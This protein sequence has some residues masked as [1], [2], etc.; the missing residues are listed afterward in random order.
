MEIRPKTHQDLLDRQA[1]P[2]LLMKHILTHGLDEVVHD[3]RRSPGDGYYWCART[4]TC[5]GPDDQVVHPS[6]CGPSRA[7]YDGPQA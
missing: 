3:E 6:R 2:S 7:C 5:V 4:C 1:C